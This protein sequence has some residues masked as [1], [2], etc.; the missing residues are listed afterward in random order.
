[1]ASTPDIVEDFLY[2]LSVAKFPFVKL[3]KEN[4][5]YLSALKLEFSSLNTK[6]KLHLFFSEFISDE[7]WRKTHSESTSDAPKGSFTNFVG[8]SDVEKNAEKL[9]AEFQQK[10]INNK[11]EEKYYGRFLEDTETVKLLTKFNGQVESF[12]KYV[13]EDPNIDNYSAYAKAFAKSIILLSKQMAIPGLMLDLLGNVTGTTIDTDITLN[14]FMFKIDEPEQRKIKHRFNILKT[15]ADEIINNEI[16]SL[17]N[18]TGKTAQIIEYAGNIAGPEIPPITVIDRALR[19][20]DIIIIVFKCQYSKYD[21]QH[22]NACPTILGKDGHSGI[23]GQYIQNI[24]LSSDVE[25]FSVQKF[26]EQITQ[27]FEGTSNH[28]LLNKQLLEIYEKSQVA[29]KYYNE[30]LTKNNGIVD[31]FL[32]YHSRPI[33]ERIDELDKYSAYITVNN[34]YLGSI[35]LGVGKGSINKERIHIS[36]QRY[37]YIADNFTLATICQNISDFLEKFN[38]PMGK[39]ENTGGEELKHTFSNKLADRLEQLDKKYRVK[40]KI[41]K[42]EAKGQSNGRLKKGMEGFANPLIPNSA[43]AAFTLFVDYYAAR[44]LE[45]Q[46]SLFFD[47]YGSMVNETALAA[48]IKRIEDFIAEA[49]KIDYYQAC[50]D[51]SNPDHRYIF[52]RLSGDFYQD[53]QMTW[54]QLTQNSA[55]ASVYGRYFLFYHYLKEDLDRIRK[56]EVVPGE[57]ERYVQ[58]MIAGIMSGF[59]ENE[60]NIQ[61]QDAFDQ[62]LQNLISDIFKKFKNKYERI[63]NAEKFKNIFLNKV[64]SGQDELLQ[65]ALFGNAFSDVRDINDD[66]DNDQTYFEAILIYCTKKDIQQQRPVIHYFVAVHALLKVFHQIRSYKLNSQKNAETPKQIGRPVKLSSMDKPYRFFS[67]DLNLYKFINAPDATEEENKRN[68][69]LN[70]QIVLETR[71]VSIFKKTSVDKLPAFLDEQYL[72]TLAP[73]NEFIDL[74]EQIGYANLQMASQGSSLKKTDIFRVWIANKKADLPKTTNAPKKGTLSLFRDGLQAQNY[75]DILKN[76]KPAIIDQTGHFIL[77]P[78]SKGAIVAWVDV[79]ERLGKINSQL[80]P[81]SKTK[82]VNELIPGLNISKRSFGNTGRAHVTYYAEIKKMI[83][84]L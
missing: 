64:R 12:K 27:R 28:V 52:K 5:C 75:I 56:D 61:D 16:Q 39:W 36:Y 82:L 70:Q 44:E 58:L 59:D 66:L 34:Y 65:S 14:I 47:A 10:V 20:L 78:R 22:P 54:E 6:P 50:T 77:G 62:A 3:V 19:E 57:V 68:W 73:K 35:Y 11:V 81:D 8:K 21:P 72:L 67:F 43:R 45:V 17:K 15:L 31:D 76:V 33:A 63:K 84:G 48:E 83:E 55:A 9:I 51:I 24:D 69:W 30:K 41:T 80:D 29:L 60:E 2:E 74:V 7:E 38:L 71:F 53:V 79:L 42:E 18:N 13:F 4:D 26:K 23:D 49:N 37:N 32:K 46:K 25:L 1:M 40:A